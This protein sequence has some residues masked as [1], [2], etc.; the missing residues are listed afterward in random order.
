MNPLLLFYLLGMFDDKD[1][2]SDIG[3]GSDYVPSIWFVLGII[4]FWVLV[5]FICFE[6]AKLF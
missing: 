5:I 2:K 6:I 1:S 4:V 3:I